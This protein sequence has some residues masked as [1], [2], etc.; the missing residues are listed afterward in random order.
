MR[1]EVDEEGEFIGITTINFIIDSEICEMKFSFKNGRFT[2]ADLKNSNGN[3]F[4][5]YEDIGTYTKLNQFNRDGK[6]TLSII[7]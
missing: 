1:F 5:T 2:T 6:I 3:T 4:I 7:V